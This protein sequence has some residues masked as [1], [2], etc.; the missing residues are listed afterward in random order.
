MG[1][2]SPVPDITSGVPAEPARYYGAPINDKRALCICRGLGVRSTIKYA[3]NVL[4]T[5]LWRAS[6]ASSL[7]LCLLDGERFIPVM[8]YFHFV[9][10]LGYALSA[11]APPTADAPS[12]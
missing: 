5:G 9:L 2:I 6:G 11:T 4:T 10:D 3:R 1:C 7:V 8:A 12:K